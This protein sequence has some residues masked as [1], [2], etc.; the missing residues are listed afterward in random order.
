MQ[1]SQS[2][3]QF[4]LQYQGRAYP[5][6][7]PQVIIGC[8]PSCDIRIENNP[9]V[10]PMHAQIISQA[11]KV[12]LQ[13]MRRDAAIW[14]NGSPASQQVLQD[15][16][17]IAV[18]DQGTR[19]KLLVQKIPGGVSS[20]T[21][22]V[23]TAGQSSQT[24]TMTP[25]ARTQSALEIPQTPGVFTVGAQPRT[26]VLTSAE[27]A[28][29]TTRYMCAAGHLS[30]NFQDYV[31]SNVVYEEHRALG[32]S[33]GVDM[34]LVVSWC[35]AGL[36][37]V[38]IRDTILTGLLLLSMVGS[39]LTVAGGI[40]AGG[41][42]MIT[43]Q[44]E[45]SSGTQASG[46]SPLL[47]IGAFLAGLVA[48]GLEVLSLIIVS[49]IEKWAR[50]KWPKFRIGFITY[51]YLL[52]I[53]LPL[54]ILGWIAIPVFW[55]TLFVELLVRYYGAPLDRLRKNT[56]DPRARPVP[57]DAA[58]EKK[59]QENF[60]TGQRNVVAY[61]GYRPFA[62]AGLYRKD[63][64][65]SFILNTSLGAKDRKRDLLGEE[66]LT[67]LPFTLNDLY[68]AV[69]N[70]VWGLGVN[71]VLE[72]EGKLYVQGKYL[73]E[74]PA[75]FNQEALRPVTSVDPML[76]EQYKEYPTEGIRYYQCLRFNFWR[77]E[78]ILTAFL[79]FVRQGKDL[80]VE[81][82]YVLLPPLDPDYYWVDE[83]ENASLFGK[84]WE[85]YMRTFDSPVQMWLKAPL[86]L[87]RGYNHA[88]RQRKLA[89]VARRNPAFDYGTST[90]VRQ[91][92]S[93]DSYHLFFQELDEEM[94][95][96]MVDKQILDTIVTFLDNHQIDTTEIRQREEM[97]LNSSTTNN[98]FGGQMIVGNNG[99]ISGN[100]TSTNSTR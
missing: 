23:H 40:I 58:L 92:A 70:D 60:V 3:S 90:S 55:G 2:V 61:S 72:I 17:E 51:F 97:I 47:V 77:G 7:K 10:L 12:F 74:S 87:L 64:A 57:L 6:N 33:Y 38:N 98:N 84:M 24:L 44:S 66:R 34:P 35:K 28:T 62:G 8:D 68:N 50:R 49:N 5:L 83:R 63:K 85:L 95:F 9:K 32:E 1:F 53:L 18:G 26:S 11:G 41:I 45:F 43:F 100:N 96:K 39:F 29:E 19:L 56:F 46:I 81:A 21:R 54:P 82:N 69:E 75:F 76:V 16:D 71:N 67:P 91:A 42:A 25:V 73:P 20:L 27:K 15:Q 65:W 79:R 4:V 89:S 22:S 59:L 37:R 31:M 86:R 14:V 80:F 99:S 88:R 13:Y 93:D 30:E 78:M 48:I 36:K 52:A 94:Y